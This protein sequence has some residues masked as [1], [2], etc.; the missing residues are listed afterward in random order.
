MFFWLGEQLFGAILTLEIVNIR[1]TN[2]VSFAKSPI[3]FTLLCIMKLSMCVLSA[4]VMYQYL[5]S[6]LGG[7]GT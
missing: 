1:V 4:V 3:W 7:K 5:K 6:K 2:I